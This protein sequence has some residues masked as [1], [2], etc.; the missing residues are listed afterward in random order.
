MVIVFI[1]KLP[2]PESETVLPVM[3]PL[4][5]VHCDEGVVETMYVPP[6]EESEPTLPK[7]RKVC[8]PVLKVTESVKV[9]VEEFAELYELSTGPARTAPFSS[10][11]VTFVKARAP[12]V[13]AT[14]KTRL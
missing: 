12:D 6:F 3:S 8:A 9:R 10:T 4:T 5:L 1:A 7:R 2:L 11:K 13:V 14:E